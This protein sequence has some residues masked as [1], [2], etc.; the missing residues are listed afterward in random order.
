MAARV[1]AKKVES[2][3]V[4]A[5]P[6]PSRARTAQR[7]GSRPARPTVVKE[8]VMSTKSSSQETSPKSMKAKKLYVVFVL[9][10]VALGLGLYYLRGLFV[11]AVVNGQPISRLEVVREAEKQKG[12]DTL[13]SLVRNNLI[14][15]EAARN[16]ASVSDKEVSDEIK[17]L[18]GVMAKQGQKLDDV[19]TTQAMT[20]DDLKKLIRLDKLVSK[21]VAKDVQVSDSEVAAYIEK[22]KDV[23]PQGEDQAKLKKDVMETL[24]QQKTSEKV[25]AWLADL[26]KRAKVIY[27]V[28][29]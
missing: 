12:K 4:V 8:A 28:Q 21:M 15:Q 13:N 1:T 2:K 25:R 17:R 18:E 10:I 3:A 24:K 11:A 16:K 20:R 9:V 5:K 22:N 29:Y 27:F 7:P 26:E 6:R 14:Q 19:L 23:L